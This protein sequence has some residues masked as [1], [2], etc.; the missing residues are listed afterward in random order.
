MDVNVV[1]IKYGNMQLRSSIL[2]KEMVTNFTG[3]R[4][5]LRLNVCVCEFIY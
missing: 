4:I 2:I 1:Y 3:N 5:F